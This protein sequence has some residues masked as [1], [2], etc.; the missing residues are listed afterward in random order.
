MDEN[1]L[2]VK[3]FLKKNL[4]IGYENFHILK[5]FLRIHAYRIIL[6]CPFR[7]TKIK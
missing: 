4:K 6:V 1:A 7:F 3:Q 2:P 5:S